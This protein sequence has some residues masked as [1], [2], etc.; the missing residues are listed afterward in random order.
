MVNIILSLEPEQ[1]EEIKHFSWVNWSEIA[2]VELVKKIIFD[3]YIKTGEISDKEWGF[4]EQIDWHPVDWLP[5]KKSY[6]KKLNK[7]KKEKSIRF[8]SVDEL[9]EAKK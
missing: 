7:I 8:N 4:C 5:L 3:S 9:F 1:K 6:I 2:R